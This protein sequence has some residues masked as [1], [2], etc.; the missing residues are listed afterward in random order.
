LLSRVP[1]QKTSRRLVAV[2]PPKFSVPVFGMPRR[3]ERF[4]FAESGSRQAIFPVFRSIALSVPQ[5]GLL[6]G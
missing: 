3:C 6:A 5:G 1:E 4:F 2:G